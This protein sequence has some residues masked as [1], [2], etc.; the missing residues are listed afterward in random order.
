MANAV[1]S[2]VTD[3]ARYMDINQITNPI[4]TVK[5]FKVDSYINKD[6]LSIKT[7]LESNGI[8]PVVL[9]NGTKI[10]NQ[11]PKIGSKLIS[12]DL[13]FLTTNDKVITMPNI[14]GWSLQEVNNLSSIL[15]IK[16]ESTGLG[17]VTSQSIKEGTIIN[18]IDKLIID[19]KPKYNLA[20]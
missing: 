12:N 13:I 14:T 1:R 5:T 8:R 2:V 10:I 7:M 16:L 18:P 11:H 6:T 17:F 4:T 3:I 15:N 9:G 19:L 20:P